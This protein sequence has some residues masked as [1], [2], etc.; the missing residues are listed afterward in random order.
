VH[1]HSPAQAIFGS[2]HGE[3]GLVLIAMVE[4]YEQD[5]NKQAKVRL[6]QLK[7]QIHDI[8]ALYYTLQS[9]LWHI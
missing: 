3:V 5:E 1:Q 6:L 9:R 2:L 8:A 4:F 7:K